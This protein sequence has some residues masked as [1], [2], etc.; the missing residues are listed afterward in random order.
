MPVGGEAAWRG[1]LPDPDQPARGVFA[2][3]SS[4]PHRQEYEPQGK[5][6]AESV[7]FVQAVYDQLMAQDAPPARGMGC[8]G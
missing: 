7:Q 3:G 2:G 6:A 4:R 8:H 5:A 1:P